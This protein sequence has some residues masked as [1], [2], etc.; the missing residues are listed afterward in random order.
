MDT[1]LINMICDLF[2]AKCIIKIFGSNWIDCEYALVS[3]VYSL[4]DLLLR[5]PPFSCG[6]VD[7]LC[8]DS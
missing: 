4:I 7:I 8:E 2:Y 1:N 5:D 6:L 3:Q